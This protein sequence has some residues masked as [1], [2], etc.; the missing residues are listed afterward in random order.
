MVWMELACAWFWDSPWEITD[1][2]VVNIALQ[3][4]YN[5]KDVT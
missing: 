4:E 1:Y 3:V 5:I 2:A